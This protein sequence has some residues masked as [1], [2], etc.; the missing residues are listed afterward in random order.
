MKEED[1]NFKSLREIEKKYLP[2][3]SKEE[4]RN[5]EII[6]PNSLGEKLAKD[7]RNT[8]KNILQGS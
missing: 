2:D 1:S 8:I 4:K 5:G 6:D 3:K 7:E